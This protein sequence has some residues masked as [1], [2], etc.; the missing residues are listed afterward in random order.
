M[1]FA[2]QKLG[3]ISNDLLELAKV[4][5]VEKP[6]LIP[7]LKRMAQMGKTLE[8]MMN[9]QGSQGGGNS[10]PSDGAEPPQGSNVAP[11]APSAMGM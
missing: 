6:A 4:L 2:M 1:Q 3:S 8:Q 9:S 5:A 10:Q 11:E 7:I